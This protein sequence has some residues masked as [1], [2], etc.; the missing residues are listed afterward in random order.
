MKFSNRIYLIYF[1]ICAT[2]KNNPKSNDANVITQFKTKKYIL[3]QKIVVN[4]SG[5]IN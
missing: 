2:I 1:Q 3:K 5:A 4:K